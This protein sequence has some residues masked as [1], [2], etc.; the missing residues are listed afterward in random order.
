MSALV[1]RSQAIDVL[2]GMTLALMI[3][4]NMSISEEKSY[5]PLLHA[6]WHGLTLTD[7]VFPSFLFAVGA[8]MSFSL[9]KYQN[10]GNAALLQKIFRRTVLIFLCGYLL[11]WFPFFEFDKAGQLAVLPIAKTRIL[12]VLQRVALAY[13]LASVILHYFKQRGAVVFSIVTLLGYWWIMAA[14]GDYTL[15]GNSAL[16]LDLY[17]L[18]EAHMYRGEGVPF[19]PEGILGTLPSVVNVL[20]GYFAG[21]LLR[22][23]GPGFEVIAKLMLWGTVLV[24]T[25]LCWSSV[26]PFNKKLWTSSY[27]LCSVGVDL[28]LLALLV[29]VIDLHA[30]R[31]WTYFFEVFGKNTLFIYLLAELLMSSMWLSHVGKLALFDWLFMNGFQWWAGDKNGSLLFAIMFMLGCWLIGYVMDKKRIYIKL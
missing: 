6:V 26:F 7:L 24:V 3:V 5:G 12:G 28:C 13:C 27:V 25:A 19:D 9:Q 29:Y 2:R 18:G 16:K 8:A 31:R 23:R 20:A 4:V 15:S 10:L 1:Q 21:R 22:D 14:G 11:Y 17:L 30:R